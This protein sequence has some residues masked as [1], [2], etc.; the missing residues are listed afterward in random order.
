MPLPPPCVL[1]VGIAVQDFV[2]SVEQLPVGAVKHRARGFVA[3][4]GGCA[5]TAAVAVARLGGRA[6]LATRLGEDLVAD[7]IVAELAGYG[8]DTAL[9]RRFPG[10]RSSVSAVM[11]DP[12]GER[13]IVNDLDPDLP[14]DPSWLPDPLPPGTRAVLS[15]T[16]W[17]RGGEAL[18]ARAKAAGLPAILDGDRTVPPDGAMLRAATHVAFSAPGLAEL[19]G[20]A[21]P[22]EGLR[23]ARAMTEAW[24]CVTDG[25]RG[26]LVAQAGG[27]VHSPAI[28][29][30]AVDTL[31]AGDV[32]HGAFA[33][34]LAEGAPEPEAVRFASGA[35]ALKCTKAGGRAGVPT[36]AETE[37][38]LKETV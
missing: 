29:V 19:T 3:V 5:A 8:V 34:A 10:R 30:R 6:V 12:A 38:F 25:E 35:A 13:M 7:L 1:C 15:D 11:V 36:R 32:W 17:P 14:D 28:P 18:L 37:T 21:D 22:A 9:C 23:A 16:R 26:A 20:L 31:G 2:F 33:L 27:V 4:G 24:I